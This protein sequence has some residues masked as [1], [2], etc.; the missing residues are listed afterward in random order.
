MTL[1]RVRRPLA[2]PFRRWRQDGLLQT[3]LWGLSD[4]AL[5]SVANFLTMVLLARGLS[6]TGLGSF[7]IVYTGLLF[8]ATLQSAMITRPHNVLGAALEGNEYVRYPTATAVSQAAFATA[9]ASVALVAA[10]AVCLMGWSFWPLMLALAPALAAWQM[11]EF[12]RQVMY[13]RCSVSQA[14]VND[15]ISYGGQVAAL[16]AGWRLG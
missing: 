8:A 6:P 14:F 13:T 7:V 3:S 11:Q 15:L 2:A 12:F 16:I 1:E 10:T 4:Q 5:I 9:A